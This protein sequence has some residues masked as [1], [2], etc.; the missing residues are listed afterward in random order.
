M[1]F[2]VNG[3]TAATLVLAVFIGL[4]V[5]AYAGLSSGA[6][7]DLDPVIE[8]ML[9]IPPHSTDAKEQWV[10]KHARFM[11]FAKAI[12]RLPLLEEQAAMVA[13]MQ[14][15]A[16]L[17]RYV[18]EDRCSDGPRGAEECDS[19]KARGLFQ[20]HEP[21]CPAI[22]QV[23]PSAERAAM[24]VDCAVR[25]Y[26]IKR[27]DCGDTLAGGL[28]G[29]RGDC[30][31]TDRPLR[32]RTAATFL[33]VLT[34]GWPTPPRGW[35]RNE[36]PAREDRRKAVASLSGRKPGEFFEIRPGVGALA[37]YHWHDFGGEVR[38]RG[39]HTG[40]SLYEALP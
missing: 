16:L 33:D 14:H 21:T 7:Q 9:R 4:F 32:A 39:W 11:P 31:T 34:H 2:R 22:W 12:E 28:A 23:P 20:L 37:E 1:R 18:A 13:L 35:K 5:M 38:P 10:Q 26:R 25:Y 15:E 30:D 27:R 24:E 19:G 36:A 8:L 6:G 17:A 40:I 3:R 29:Y